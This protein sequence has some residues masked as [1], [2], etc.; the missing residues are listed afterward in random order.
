MDI[1]ALDEGNFELLVGR[2]ILFG[3]LKDLTLDSKKKNIS[4]AY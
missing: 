3:G 2:D 4:F 1:A